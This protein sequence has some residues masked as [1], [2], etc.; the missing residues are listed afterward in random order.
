MLNHT[1]KSAVQQFM[2]RQCPF[3][4]PQAAKKSEIFQI[5]RSRLF[6]ALKMIRAHH[7]GCRIKVESVRPDGFYFTDSKKWI[8]VAADCLVLTSFS[9]IS[10][11]RRLQS[12]L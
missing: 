8:W 4:S 1:G 2:K 9:L 10:Y 5:K 11:K 6:N 12:T 3:E 7:P